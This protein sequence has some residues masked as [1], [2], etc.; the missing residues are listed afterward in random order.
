MAMEN[1]LLMGDFPIETPI[2]S[3]FPI[4]MFDYQ[5]VHGKCNQQQKTGC[6]TGLL[7]CLSALFHEKWFHVKP[8]PAQ[9]LCG[10]C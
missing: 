4:A 9:L 5:R 1:T 8:D 3:E 6:A 7:Q 10:R 2:S